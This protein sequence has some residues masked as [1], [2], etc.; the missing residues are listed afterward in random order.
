MILVHCTPQI[1]VARTWTQATGLRR[2]HQSSAATLP[3]AQLHVCAGTSPW[4]GVYLAATMQRNAGGLHLEVGLGQSVHMRGDGARKRGDWAALDAVPA[5]QHAHQPPLAARIGHL[6][7]HIHMRCAE[8]HA[9]SH[10]A[11]VTSRCCPRA[12]CVS[13]CCCLHQPAES[14]TPADRLSRQACHCVPLACHL[15]RGM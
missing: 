9:T 3:A 2:K 7:A 12:E 5:L 10:P 11:H 15:G 1:R 13:H 6:C 4:T 14:P 8:R